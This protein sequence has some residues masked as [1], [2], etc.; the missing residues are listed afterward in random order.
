MS[1]LTG[2]GT[3]YV[4]LPEATPQVPVLGSNAFFPVRRIYCVGSNYQEHAREMGTS[5]REP[6][7]FFSK[8]ANAVFTGEAVPYPPMTQNLHHEVE[9]VVA[10]AGGGL[11]IPEEN[12][13]DHVFG[14]A[15]GV[16]LTRRDLQAEAK[17]QGRP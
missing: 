17:Q 8:P 14:Y 4:F 16:D 15:V 6:P 10:L 2:L 9:L 13:L 7:C 5:L 11:R 12:A 1:T 3:E